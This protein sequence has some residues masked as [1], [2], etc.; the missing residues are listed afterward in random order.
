MEEHSESLKLLAE[1]VEALER[2]VAALEHGELALPSAPAPAAPLPSLSLS[3]ESLSFVGDGGIFPVLGKAML[4]IAGA[5]LLRAAMQSST[6]PHLLTILVAV[7]YA[8]LWLIPAARA[9]AGEKFASVVWASTSAIILFPMLWELTMRFQILPGQSAAVILG[10]YAIV[11]STLAW[12]HHFVAIS[13]IANGS[14]SIATL[15]FGIATR[16]M[17]PFFIA[18]LFIALVGEVAATSRRSLR[19]RPVIALAAD[20]AVFV[21]IAIYSG[22]P[23]SHVDYPTIGASLLLAFAPT[24]LVIYAASAVTQTVLLRRGISIFEI[25]QTLTAALLTVWAVLAFLPGH[26][27][28]VLGILCLIASAVGY[29]V[30]FGLFDRIHA[31]R[32][33]HVYAVGSLA[34]LLLGSYLSLQPAWLALSLSALSCIL[35]F[36]GTRTT[37]ATLLFHGIALLLFAALSSA[38]FSFFAHTMVGLSLIPPGW[39]VSCVCIA[40]I[41]CYLALPH[42]D[43]ARWWDRL[44]RILSAALATTAATTFLVWLLAQITSD[45][46]NPKASHIA[47]IRTFALCIVALALAWIGSRL[48]RLELSWLVWVVLAFAALKIFFEDLQHGQFGFTAAS[49]FLYA[50]TI[51]LVPR[52]PHLGNHSTPHASH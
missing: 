41:L 12:N 24:L 11:A 43:P 17:V 49:I 21:L 23:E 45:G 5:Y 47:V 3:A 32:N 22:A 18:S 28:L 16:Q 37:H 52:L 35:V 30:V 8:F 29:A 7:V 38:Q 6:L 2:R 48:H 10:A 14:A 1:R 46:A 9:A 34:L 40:A 33:Y 15:A 51:I 50:V 4:G 27:A 31:E 25:A 20:L 26:G 36:L 44:L 19:A 42:V 13:W 39:I